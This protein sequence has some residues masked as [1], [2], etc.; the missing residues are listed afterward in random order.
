MGKRRKRI[1][2]LKVWSIMGDIIEFLTA[3]AP[4][5]QKVLAIDAEL[6]AAADA[7]QAYTIKL[8]PDQ[9]KDVREHGR[10]LVK[11]ARKVLEKWP[12]IPQL[13]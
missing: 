12:T 6:K 10:P 9:I 8:R 11:L 4:R 7:G 13:P 2:W 5:T 3:L 1:N